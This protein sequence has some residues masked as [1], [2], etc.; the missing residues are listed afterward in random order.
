MS[1][2]LYMTRAGAGVVISCH[3]RI[4]FGPETTSLSQTVRDTL[5][6]SPNV[7]LNLAAVTN[8]DSGGLGAL[9]GLVLSAR[10]IGGD[11]KLCGLTPKLRNLLRITRLEDVIEIRPD[12]ES[13]I[14]AFSGRAAA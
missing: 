1:L 5:T 10:R 6:E 8:V 11:L 7:V 13:A 4:V 2:Q 14:A 12:A 3:G 9:V